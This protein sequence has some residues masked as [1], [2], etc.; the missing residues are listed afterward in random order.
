MDRNKIKMISNNNCI[1]YYFL[2]ENGEWMRIPNSSVL[3][4]KEYM[5]VVLQEKIRDILKAIA[6]G[7]NMGNRGVDIFF[8]GT[9]Q[10][11]YIIQ[12]TIE[13][14]FPEENIVCIQKS[15][16]IAVVGKVG[17]G[18]TVLIEE[19]NNYM[20]SMFE[21]ICMDSYIVYQEKGSNCVWYELHGMDIDQESVKDT[22]QTIYH[23][24]E[25]GITVFLYCIFSSK[26]ESIEKNIILQIKEE[27]PEIVVLVVL[28]ASICKEDGGYAENL[29]RELKNVKVIPVLARELKTKYGVISSYGVDNV[30]KAIFGGTRVG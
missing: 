20:G 19:V 25:E 4:R 23:L 2:N 7:Y 16:K 14:F 29:S 15:T 17:S 8:E 24:I 30:A 9:N 12:S 27:H 11:Y 1:F 10:E 3:S 26:I 6:D 28:T 18:K 22:K 21:M 13:E 5:Q